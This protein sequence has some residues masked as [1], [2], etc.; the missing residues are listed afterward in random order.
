MT[1]PFSYDFHFS[2]NF[3]IFILPQFSEESACLY[4][5]N[6]FVSGGPWFHGLC[7]LMQFLSLNF[8]SNP[9]ILVHAIL[10]PAFFFFNTQ[11]ASFP[12]KTWSLWSPWFQRFQMSEEFLPNSWYSLPARYSGYLGE[13]CSF[14][15]LHWLFVEQRFTLYSLAAFFCGLRVGAEETSFLSL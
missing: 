8:S 11:N 14:S 5:K 9:G 3:K 13:V 12:S 6:P 10:L 7:R 1:L 4:K 15:S 2:F